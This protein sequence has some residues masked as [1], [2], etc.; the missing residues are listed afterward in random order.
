[1][2]ATTG[3]FFNENSAK[4]ATM[5]QIL[6]ER[7]QNTF[8]SLRGRGTLTEDDVANACREIRRALLEADVAL[9]VVKKLIDKVK[10]EAV[11]EAITK[12][13]KPGEQVVKIVH[14]ALV[15]V[16]GEPETFQLTNKK[17]AVI[18]M[19]GLQG[20]GKTTT[21]AKLAKHLQEKENKTTMLASL[22]VYRP[23]AQ[24]QLLTLAERIN[25]PM[26][27]IRDGEKPLEITKRALA[28]AAKTNAD[29]LI[30]DTAGRLE[31]DETLMDELQ[32]V[33]DLAQPEQTLLVVDSLTGQ[34]AVQVAQSFQD[35][36]GL[37]GLAFTRV[38]GDGRGGA[39]LSV[40]DVTGVPIYFLGLGEAVD[41]LEL[42]RPEGLAG[43]ILGQGD[44]VALVEKMQSAVDED[45]AAS[46]QEKLLSGSSFDMNDIRKQLNMIRKMGNLKGMMGLIPGMGKFKK[47]L[48]GAKMDDKMIIHQLAIIDSMTKKERLN[49]TLLNA[50]RRQRI[51]AG[52]GTSVADVNKLMKMHQQMNQM[53]KML[54]SGKFP[55]MPM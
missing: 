7:L 6:A 22:D 3:C 16:L 34:V 17:P 26:L 36:I 50:R 48:D 30:L 18:L 53:S 40:R 24:Q 12:S 29:V 20:S 46:L 49:P 51:A 1:M 25:A 54:R 19:C 35:Q 4:T 32:Q 15:D 11:G 45:E 38:D 14:D 39:V 47:Q 43:R 31:L 55:N 28:Q 5:F 13:V 10:A 27:D 42:Y 41:K 44:V 37:T 8:S 2:H 52:S 9:P 33:R 23:A 21:S